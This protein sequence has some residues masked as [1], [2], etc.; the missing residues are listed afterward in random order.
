[1]YDDAAESLAALEKVVK[2]EKKDA[3]LRNREAIRP[4]LEEEIAV[5]YYY[6]PAGIR[7][8]IRTDRQLHEAVSKWEE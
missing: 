1:M 8:R 2:M 5:R 6:Q 3:L 4:L 7:I